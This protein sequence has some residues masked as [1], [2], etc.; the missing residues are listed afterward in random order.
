MAELYNSRRTFLQSSLALSTIGF[1]GAS[2]FEPLSRPANETDQ[3]WASIRKQF[4][5]NDGLIYMN[6]ASLG[7]PPGPV[8]KAVQD[9]YTLLSNNPLQGKHTLTDKIREEAMPALARFL[10]VRA[11]EIT[12]LRNASEGLWQLITGLHLKNGDEVIITSQE[13]PAGKKPWKFRAANE[14]IQIKEVAIPSPL[15]SIEDTVSRIESAITP[16][17]RAIAFCLVTRGGHLY[18]ATEICQMARHRG[19]TTLVDGAQAIGMTAI[20]LKKIGCDA[21]AASLH[22]WILAPIGNGMAWVSHE[23]RNKFRSLYDEQST[24]ENPNYAP[25]GTADLPTK[26][27]VADALKFINTI[28]IHAIENRNRFLSNHLK[29]LLKQKPEIKLLSSA[30]KLSCPGST[31]FE[32]S[33]IDPVEEVA[34]LESVGIYIDEHVRDGHQA[35]RISTHFY[36]SIEEIEHVVKTIGKS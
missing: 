16:R 27:A 20:D 30:D 34:R 32:I 24:I 15:L 23:A 10:N 8:M 31:I 4:L 3:Q 25:I 6:N 11:D 5:L 29:T 35:L 18:P 17:T 28:S 33:G 36:N 14:N 21:F 7:L 22:K 1:M 19:I 26:A 13:H 9:G 2:S 12:L